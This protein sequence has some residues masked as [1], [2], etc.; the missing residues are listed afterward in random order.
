MPRPRPAGDVE[1]HHGELARGVRAEFAKAH[2]ADAHVL[3]GG[4]HVVVVPD[5]LVLLVIIHA[6]LAMMQQHMQQHPFAHAHRQVG[7]DHARDRNVWQVGI[8]EDEIDAG[9]EREHGFQIRQVLQRA[10]AMFPRRDIFDLLAAKVVRG[11]DDALFRQQA[12]EAVEPGRDVPSVDGD[13]QGHSTPPRPSGA[14][15]GAA[16]RSRT[17]P[18]SGGAPSPTT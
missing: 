4:L 6:L 7:I 14:V 12:A 1:A 8:G 16:R 17:G 2:H 11:R 5:L 13:E 15:W 9:A 18:R 3:G 10:E